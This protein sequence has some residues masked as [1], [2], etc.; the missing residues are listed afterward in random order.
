MKSDVPIIL[1]SSSPRRKE[2]L[3][4]IYADF[5]ICPVDIDETISDNSDVYS[6]AEKLAI[7]KAR[8]VGKSSCLVIGC[9]TVVIIDNTIL[10]KPKN[11]SDAI[12][13]L[14]QLS[15][16][17][18][19]VVTGVCIIYNDRLYSFSQKTS[20]EFYSL[21]ENDISGYVMTGEP[22]DKAGAYGIQ[23]LG[24]LFVKGIQGDFY[25]VV[26]LPIS[27]LRIKLNEILENS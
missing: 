5:E 19:D 25:N 1:A 16:K 23:G 3:S 21:K 12:R 20:V 15:G 18:H 8:A 2:L 13:M 22:L 14:K 10:G 24:S 27:K 4:M 17:S 7:K 26:G 9:D 6:V 11:S